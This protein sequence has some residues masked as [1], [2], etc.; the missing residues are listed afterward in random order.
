[1]TE[2]IDRE[3][4]LIEMD[5]G[6]RAGNYEEGF[7]NYQHVNCMDDCLDVVRY[8][9]TADVVE[10]KEYDI[11]HANYTANLKLLRK[12]LAKNKDLRSKINKAIDEIEDYN[13][14]SNFSD[15]SES[16]QLGVTKGLDLASEILKRNI[17]E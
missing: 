8:A 3:K 13:I 5:C 17:G 7:E 2:Y 4:V 11:L 12:E 1:M 16:F 15:C 6:I 10:R 9:D 14:K